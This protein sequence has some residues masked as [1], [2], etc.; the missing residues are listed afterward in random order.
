VSDFDRL[1]TGFISRLSCVRCRTERMDDLTGDHP[2]ALRSQ[3]PPG[4][5]GEDG[6]EELR[7][8]NF[9]CGADTDTVDQISLSAATIQET[10]F[11]QCPKSRGSIRIRTAQGEGYQFLPFLSLPSLVATVSFLL[12]YLQLSLLSGSSS[13][14]FNKAKNDG[15]KRGGET[16][17]L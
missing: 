10:L 2:S 11:C 17:F 8:W 16:M 3:G 9:T 4:G 7:R 13:K 12:T 1:E 14:S 5:V 6:G 15:G